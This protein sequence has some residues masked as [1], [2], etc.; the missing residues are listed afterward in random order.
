MQG[1]LSQGVAMLELATASTLPGKPNNL[2]NHIKLD[3]IKSIVSPIMKDDFNLRLKSI[4][5][6]C[7]AFGLPDNV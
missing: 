1:L 6:A 7:H 2:R 5:T 4:K 3:G